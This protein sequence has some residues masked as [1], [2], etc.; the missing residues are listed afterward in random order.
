[1]GVFRFV[2]AGGGDAEREETGVEAGELGLDAGVV[3]EIRVDEFAEFGLLLVGWG[4]NDGEDL[5]HVGV[6]EAF[7]QDALANHS[8]RSKENYFHVVMLPCGAD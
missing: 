4:A 5:V 8:R 6:E 3:E 7:A 2:H 1:M